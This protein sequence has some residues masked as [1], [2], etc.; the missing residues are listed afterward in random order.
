[1]KGPTWWAARDQEVFQDQDPI[2]RGLVGTGE[3][4]WIGRFLGDGRNLAENP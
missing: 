2:A 4:V 3:A 1:M